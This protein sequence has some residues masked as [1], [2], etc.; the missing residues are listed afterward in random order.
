MTL[1]YRTAVSEW[2]TCAVLKA[3]YCVSHCMAVVRGVQQPFSPAQVLLVEDVRCR[4]GNDCHGKAGNPREQNR[5]LVESR[6]CKVVEDGAC[7]AGNASAG[8]E[9]SGIAEAPNVH[10]QGIGTC[11]DPPAGPSQP[12]QSAALAR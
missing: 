4:P 2:L 12:A 6:V 1:C 11:G 9:S 3:H 5:G 7:T 10:G 8:R